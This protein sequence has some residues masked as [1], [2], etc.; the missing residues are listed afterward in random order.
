LTGEKETL[1][2]TL[3]AKA[4]DNRS[5]HPILHDTKADKIAAQIEYDFA[6]FEGFALGRNG[7]VLR[8]RQLDEWLRAFLKADP[9]RVIL[10][11]GYIQDMYQE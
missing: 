4:F 11:P 5:K 3:Y 2:I 8:A 6:K 9:H 10:N 7:I 1:L